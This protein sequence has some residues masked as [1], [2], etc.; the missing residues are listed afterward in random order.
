MHLLAVSILSTCFFSPIT[1]LQRS[2]K[3]PTLI[4]QYSSRWR[5]LLVNSDPFSGYCEEVEEDKLRG[6]G[7][8]KAWPVKYQGRDTELL[9]AA[10]PS[11]WE[12]TANGARLSATKHCR[13]VRGGRENSLVLSA[14]ILGSTLL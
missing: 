9:G 7:R 4:L 6:G 10:V 13:Q 1:E 14:E 11:I 5:T 8:S 2:L 12:E 3:G